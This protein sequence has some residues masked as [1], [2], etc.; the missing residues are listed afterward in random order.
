MRSVPYPTQ[1]GQTT[2]ALEK[3]V[4]NHEG[5]IAFEKINCKN[6]R[7]FLN[8]VLVVSIFLLAG[9]LDRTE[10]IFCPEYEMTLIAESE[11]PL[12]D[13][14]HPGSSGIKRGMEGG[15]IF[16]Q[17]GEYRMFIT[18]MLRSDYSGTRNGYWKS[19]DGVNWD[20]VATIQESDD[21]IMGLK[22][23]VWSP[24]PFFNR[25]EKR[26]NLFYVGYSEKGVLK[27]NVFRAISA[28]EGEDGFAGPYIDA[29]GTVLS[30]DDKGKDPW[31]NLQGTDSFYP[32]PVGEKWYAFYGSSDGRTYW[33]NGMAMADSLGGQWKR[34]AIR[35]PT[36][37]YSENPIV[38]NL[39]DGTYFCVFDDLSYGEESS[40]MG[41][42]YST[43]GINWKQKVLQFPM[44]QWATNVR[45]PQQIIPVPEEENTF[46]LYF[47]AA[48]PSGFYSFGRMKVKISL[49]SVPG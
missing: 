13:S 30:F 32:F 44:P 27:G 39:D 22:G 35:I 20:R 49:R 1:E 45:T 14:S 12:I 4:V 6:M 37:T 34:D 21:N 24:M 26:W 38:I 9:C 47:T 41:Y 15:T 36:F 3:P 29:P 7:L 2:V 25:Q 28:V 40:T 33:V 5:K 48:T 16:W 17:G 31:E 10:K 43:D 8:L 23:S 11:A 18:E 19:K 42:G 46:W